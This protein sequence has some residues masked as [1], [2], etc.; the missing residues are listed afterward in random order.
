METLNRKG[1]TLLEILLV[2]AVIAILAAL[3]VPLWRNMLESEKVT[4]SGDIIRAEIGATRVNAIRESTEFVFCY[5][6]ETGQFWN[7]PLSDSTSP[8]LVDA[9]YRKT[10]LPP[11]NSLPEGV[12]FVQGEV[13]ETTRSMDAEEDSGTATN[14]TRII[15]YPDGSAQNASVKVTNESGDMIQVTVRGVTGTTSASGF[16]AE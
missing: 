13:Q 5:I 6:P 14:C 2:V 4:R 7:E 8:V 12:T 10:G 9:P 3:S 16:L 1:I 11:S 15:F